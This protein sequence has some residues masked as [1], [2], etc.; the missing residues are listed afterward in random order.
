[1]VCMRNEY[2]WG[3]IAGTTSPNIWVRPDVEQARIQKVIS[4]CDLLKCGKPGLHYFC[5]LKEAK[6]YFRACLVYEPQPF[7]LPDG[8]EGAQ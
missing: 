5:E 6:S 2:G 8:A 7:P 4:R 3:K 1:M